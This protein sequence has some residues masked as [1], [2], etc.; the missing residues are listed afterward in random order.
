[1][2]YE[3]LGRC[4]GHTSLQ[5]CALQPTQVMLPSARWRAV[6]LLPLAQEAV[7]E[8]CTGPNP[9]VGTHFFSPIRL[10][11]SLL[12]SVCSRLRAKN[13]VIRSYEGR[14]PARSFASMNSS[15]Y[16]LLAL[17]LVAWVLQPVFGLY[18]AAI[19]PAAGVRQHRPKLMNIGAM[20]MNKWVEFMNMGG[21]FM[22]MRVEFMDTRVEF[23]N[24]RVEFMNTRVE[25][26]NMRVKFMNMGV[27][28]MNMRVEFTN[29][30]VEFMNSWVKFMNMR[31]K[32]MS[33]RVARMSNSACTVRVAAPC[34]DG[35]TAQRTWPMPARGPPLPRERISAQCGAF[36]RT[37]L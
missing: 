23:M 32:L 25:F 34:K 5:R 21:K 3:H 13:V 2:F 37:F 6:G 4:S 22:N 14:K 9:P 33:T 1:M 35:R 8:G 7:C 17:G 28:F 10:V 29:M 12:H 30:R 19:L 16:A 31:A 18:T 26:M 36:P 20:F 27:K 15:W 11:A 24:T